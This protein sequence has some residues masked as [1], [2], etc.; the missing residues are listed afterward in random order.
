M[1]LRTGW[2]ALPLPKQSEQ[3]QPDLDGAGD[4]RVSTRAGEWHEY[5]G[6]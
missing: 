5:A 1:E 6:V 4:R 3:T 2:D